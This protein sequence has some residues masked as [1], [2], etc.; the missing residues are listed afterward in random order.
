MATRAVLSLPGGWW[1]TPCFL[2]LPTDNHGLP[3]T[4]QN[5][6]GCG[7]Q[8][9][10]GPGGTAVLEVPYDGCHVTEW[11]RVAGWREP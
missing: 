5:D 10:Q 8:V 6:S 9:T 4:L 3:H 1:L 2:R 11:V 7:T